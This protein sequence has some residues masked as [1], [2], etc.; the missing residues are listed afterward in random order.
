MTPSIATPLQIDTGGAMTPS[1]ATPVTHIAVAST[2]A[3]RYH[4]FASSACA[5]KESR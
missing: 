3:Y 5:A 2:S 1:I 4:A